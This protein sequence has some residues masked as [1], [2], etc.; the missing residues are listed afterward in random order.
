MVT[1]TTSQLLVVTMLPLK[2]I[3]FIVDVLHILTLITL[4]LQY[5]LV[6]KL[7]VVLEVLPD[8]M[9]SKTDLV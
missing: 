2:I 7:E 4:L 1:V 9:T 5:H 8:L 6:M 3:L